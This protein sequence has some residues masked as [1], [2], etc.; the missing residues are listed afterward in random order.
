MW[1]KDS[2]TFLRLFHISLGLW[3]PYFSNCI[4]VRDQI[5][6]YIST[7]TAY[8]NWL[9]VKVNIS[10]IC[11]LS[12][13]WYLQKM[14]NVSLLTKIYFLVEIQLFFSLKKWSILFPMRLLVME[15]CPS[16]PWSG[17]WPTLGNTDHFQGLVSC[18]GR[19]GQ[20]PFSD[21]S[22]CQNSVLVRLELLWAIFIATWRGPAWKW[23]KFQRK[24]NGKTGGPD[25]IV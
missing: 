19:E 21:F 2:W 3:S 4:S 10:V 6:S 5:S 9:N 22:S 13:T 16:L 1:C 7:K 18:R 14:W 15:L 8:H 12:Q 23:S 25:V 24:Q 11:L 20:A 17:M